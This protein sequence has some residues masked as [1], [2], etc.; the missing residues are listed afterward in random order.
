MVLLA[1]SVRL[2]FSQP[3]LF[4]DFSYF[5]VA[6]SYLGVLQG[7]R[8]AYNHLS[9]YNHDYEITSAAEMPVR[10]TLVLGNLISSL[11]KT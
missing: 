5:R 1:F 3:L 10:L 11:K 9:P 4:W 6:Y 7:R 2:L 8:N